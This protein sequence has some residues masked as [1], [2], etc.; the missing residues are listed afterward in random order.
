MLRPFGG[1]EQFVY[2]GFEAPAVYAGF[3]ACSLEQHAVENQVEEGAFAVAALV[4][5]VEGFEVF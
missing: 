4:Y 3:F 1:T 5:H 2:C